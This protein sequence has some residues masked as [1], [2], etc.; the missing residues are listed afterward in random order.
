MSVPLHLI[1]G[2]LGSGKTSFLKYYIEKFGTR[3]RIAIIQN[4]FSSVNI[5]K[6]D[7]AL[8]EDY[9]ILE[10]NN[11]SAFCVCLLGSF[12]KSLSAFIDDVKP[13][14]LLMEA[15]GISDTIGVGQIFQSKDLMKKVFLAHVWCIVDARNLNK[16]RSFR[17]RFERQIQVADTIIINK[18]SE[19]EISFDAIKNQI[20]AVNPYAT[21]L[22][23]DYCQVD[24]TK[25]EKKSFFVPLMSNKPAGRP[26]LSSLVIK[27]TKIIS[28]NNLDL[29]L[30]H[31]K[32]DCIRCKGYVNIEGGETIL[33]QGVFD[34]YSYVE[35]KKN[36][37]PTELILIGTFDS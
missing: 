18:A 33:V 20:K 30:Q 28:Q 11:G 24:L 25:I 21:M 35:V 12:I 15:S 17:F 34:D 27:S 31:I 7:L 8:N 26:N 32:E 10:V 13:D 5:D 1:S 2:F 19:T 3:R 4:E 22:T 37:G 6:Q 16:M 36:A 23:G 9:R 14:E 29:F